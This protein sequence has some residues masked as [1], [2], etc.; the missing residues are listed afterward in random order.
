MKNENLIDQYDLEGTSDFIRELLSNLPKAYEVSDYGQKQVLIGSIYPK[1]ITFHNSKL[2]N[3]NISSIYRDIRD[4]TKASVSLRVGDRT[5]TGSLFLH[6][7][8]L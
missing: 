3:R 5:R 8:A 4:T 6:R 1:G 7:E 2:L